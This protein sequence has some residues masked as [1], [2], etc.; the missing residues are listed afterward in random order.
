MQPQ[1]LPGR[2]CSCQHQSGFLLRSPL[3]PVCT[4]FLST[5]ATLGPSSCLQIPTL[6]FL[7]LSQSYPEYSWSI[8]PLHWHIPVHCAGWMPFYFSDFP[9]CCFFFRSLTLGPCIGRPT[10]H[11]VFIIYCVF[12]LCI[13][14]ESI[15][16]IEVVLINCR[17]VSQ[18]YIRHSSSTL[19]SIISLIT[20]KESNESEMTGLLWEEKPRIHG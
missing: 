15:A 16:F 18:F 14:L 19:C 13:S 17:E 3:Y 20:F 1:N 7:Q 11:H 9:G 8:V 2:F 6:V 10:P 4:E 12:I 5:M